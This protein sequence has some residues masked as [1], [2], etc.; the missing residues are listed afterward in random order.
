MGVA[1]VAHCL[2]N[3]NSKVGDGA[4]C[5]GVYSPLIDVLRA[6]GWRIEQ[7]PCP[8][9]AFAGLNRF[10]AVREQYD[11]AAYRRHCRRLATAVADAV[12]LRAGQGEEIVLVGVEGSPSMGVTI[13]SSDPQRGGRPAWPDGTPEHTSGEGIFVAELHAE[14]DRRGIVFRVAGETHAIPGQDE[15]VQRARLEAVLERG[16]A[17]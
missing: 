9:L 17:G 5:A 2:L 14:L 16:D 1:F 3:Q 12:A 7:M 8:E 4:H 13:T 10:W 11:T 6:R 15:A